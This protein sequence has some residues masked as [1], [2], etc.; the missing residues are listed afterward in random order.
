MDKIRWLTKNTPTNQNKLYHPLTHTS[1]CFRQQLMGKTRLKKKKK[2]KRNNKEHINQNK[3]NSKFLVEFE[4]GITQSQLKYKTHLS[5]LKYKLG[6]K[7]KR[8]H[9]VT[10]EKSKKRSNNK[11]YINQKK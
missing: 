1:I 10:N 4:M 11:E 5:G 2:K 8:E 6:V 3:Q 7:E 9:K